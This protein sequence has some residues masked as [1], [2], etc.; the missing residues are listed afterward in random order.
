MQASEAEPLILCISNGQVQIS[1]LG[2]LLKGR[3]IQQ[4]G[5]EWGAILFLILAPGDAAGLWATQSVSWH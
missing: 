4:V 1:L 3:L 5:V 2:L